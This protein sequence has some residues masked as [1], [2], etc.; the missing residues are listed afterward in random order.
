MHNVIVSSSY[1]STHILLNR[2]RLQP[3]PQF[4][5]NSTNNFLTF[6]HILRPPPP[7]YRSLRSLP[8][9]EHHSE[10]MPHARSYEYTSREG[11]CYGRV[12]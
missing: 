4:L 5:P 8:R 10:L 3:L 1:N 7:T 11:I 12:I 9:M 6:L 2:H